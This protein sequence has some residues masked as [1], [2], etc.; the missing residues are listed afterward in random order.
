[1][2]AS[3]ADDRHL[4]SLLNSLIG[5]LAG[6]GTDT[7][8]V[9]PDDRA[10]IEGL[11]ALERLR[12]I[13]P[14]EPA[15]STTCDGCE[16]ACPMEVVWPGRDRPP[17]IVCDKRDDIGPVPVDPEQLRQWSIS[18]EGLARTLARLADLGDQPQLMPEYSGWHL[19]KLS[20]DG[21]DIP[22]RLVTADDGTSYQGFTISMVAGARD[23]RAASLAELLVFPNG[24][25]VLDREVLASALPRRSDEVA[26]E[27]K[28]VARQI[29]LFNH[30][31]GKSRTLAK[32]DFNSVNDNVFQ[33]L[34]DSPGRT[35]SLDEV[36]SIAHSRSLPSLGKIV[37]KLKFTGQ[38]RTLFFEVSKTAI[39]FKQAATVGEL[40]ALG[41]EPSSID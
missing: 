1:M 23:G 6:S 37:E 30:V 40:K 8:L 39:R 34:F 25:L 33:A 3:A 9:R 7:A 4:S 5:R 32:P 31:T 26:L 15:R 38:L 10:E 11:A 29:V 18:L 12:L 24:Q 16:R 35:F 19:G 14:A 20:A 41:I 2:P 22:V 21:R 13:A 27:I 17:F 36:R 28:Y